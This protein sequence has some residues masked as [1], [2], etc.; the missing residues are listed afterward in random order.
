MQMLQKCSERS[1]FRHLGEGVHILGEALAAIAVFTVRTGDISVRVVDIAR[2]QHSRMHL[3]PVGSHLLAVFTAGV[4]VGDL[5]GT[6]HIMHVLGELGL[7]GSHDGKLLAD[8]NLGEQLMCPREHH[9]LSLEV[10][11][12]GTFG[13]ELGHIVYL[14][15]RLA[16]KHLAGARKYGG[17]DEHGHV[18]EIADQLLHEREVL[19]AVV[20][21]GDM[22]L[23]KSDVDMAQIIVIAFG[24]VA[25]EQL[26]LGIVVFQPILE[27]TAHEAAAYD[28][29]VDHFV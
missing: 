12:I 27:G 11:D 19:C 20:L 24:R 3:V 16:G 25:D 28:S 17:A 29:D 1:S 15:S 22:Y 6:E 8:K 23:N 5:V 9:R 4:E 2:E 14:V 13:E 21:G 26:A 10:L 18:G 7:Q